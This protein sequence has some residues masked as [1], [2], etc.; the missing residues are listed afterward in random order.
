[1]N[2]NKLLQEREIKT[3]KLNRLITIFNRKLIE[4]NNKKKCDGDHIFCFSPFVENGTCRF[5]F[6]YTLKTNRELLLE[7]YHESLGV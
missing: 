1:M 2:I 4:N 3:K 5:C 7:S 6:G